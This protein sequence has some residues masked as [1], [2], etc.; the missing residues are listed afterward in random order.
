MSQ[1]GLALFVSGERELS[2]E[3]LDA[4]GQY[5]RLKIIE[6]RRARTAKE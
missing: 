4:V 2:I 3:A 6:P 5:L 1:G